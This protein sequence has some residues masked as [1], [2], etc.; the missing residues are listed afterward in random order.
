MHYSQQYPR[1]LIRHSDLLLPKCILERL[2]RPHLFKL[3]YKF[4]DILRRY[5][6]QFLR[7]VLVFQTDTR[8]HHLVVYQFQRVFTNVKD[9]LDVELT[10]A[11]PHLECVLYL[12]A[13]DKTITTHPHDVKRFCLA[14][15][16]YLH[17]IYIRRPATAQSTS[18]PTSE[19]W[20]A[21]GPGPTTRSPQ[22]RNSAFFRHLRAACARLSTSLRSFS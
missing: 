4:R 1:I 20:A 10:A 13:H 19:Y 14:G 2:R 6:Q 8:N 16:Y 9:V 22:P 11:L 12:S 17:V 3:S 7:R 18:F 15:H 21:Y 5:L